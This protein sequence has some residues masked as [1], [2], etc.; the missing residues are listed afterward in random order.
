MHCDL[1]YFFAQVEERFT[2]RFKGRPIVVGADPKKGQG[3]GV[4]STGNYEAR[5]FGIKSGMPI[6]RAWRLCPQ[7]VFLPVNGQ[8]YDQ[9]SGRIM[10]LLKVYADKFEQ[11]S[12]DEAF[13]DV[14]SA[15]SYAQAIKIARRIKQ[16][17]LA[18]EKLTASIGLGP[19][20]LVAKIASDFKKPEGL[21]VVRPGEVEKFLAP[22]DISELRGM[23]P[24][25]STIVRN[26]GLKTIGDIQRAD[27]VALVNKLGRRGYEIFRQS[28]GKA[29]DEVTEEREIKS[30]GRETTFE[31]DTSDKRLIWEALEELMREVVKEIEGDGLKF[32]TVTLKVR[33]KNFKTFDRSFTFKDPTD[34]LRMLK[35][36]TLKLLLPFIEKRQLLR[37]VGVRVSNFRPPND[38]LYNNERASRYQDALWCP[39]FPRT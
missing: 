22:L 38:S 19:N 24:Q 31:K 26:M 10:A 8:L 28:F 2:P 34:E 32:K 30:V 39:S 1:D 17:I 25:N 15:G 20:K 4:V 37:L 5:K 14:T 3:R 6:S 36:I 29:S 27:P 13:L 18:K 21:T 7:A 16:E 35:R 12:V 11:V 9:V 23:G 33:L